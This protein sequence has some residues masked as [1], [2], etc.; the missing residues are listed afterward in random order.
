MSNTITNNLNRMNVLKETLT[1]HADGQLLVEFFLGFD[2]LGKPLINLSGSETVHCIKEE[3][4]VTMLKRLLFQF[5]CLKHQQKFDTVSNYATNFVSVV[6]MFQQKLAR[7][8]DRSNYFEQC[9]IIGF[10]HLNETKKL[11]YEQTLL[12]KKQSEERV[13]ALNNSMRLLEELQKKEF[14]IEQLNELCSKYIEK[15]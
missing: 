14:V 3:L 6:N 15:K 4:L 9:S 12:N 2:N 10:N 11:L 5:D 7:V 1:S 13:T 8:E